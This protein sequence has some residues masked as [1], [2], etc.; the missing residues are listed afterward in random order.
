MSSLAHHVRSLVSEVSGR[1]KAAREAARNRYPSLLEETNTSPELVTEF[2]GVTST[3][4]KGS[5]EVDSDIKI[6]Q[7]ARQLQQRIAHGSKLDN[8]RSDAT[9]AVEAFNEETKAF[10]EA[11]KRKHWELVQGANALEQRFIEG[12]KA[13]NDFNAL[14]LEYAEL[15]IN[16]PIAELL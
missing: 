13:V 16:E 15:L 8:A 11:R 10:L 7:R 14:K 6:L 1:H 4:G 12:Q 3:L 5:A 2:Q 9:K